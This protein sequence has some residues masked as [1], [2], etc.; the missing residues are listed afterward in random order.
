MVTSWKPRD[1][2]GL[3]IRLA[4]VWVFIWG[5][6]NLLAAVKQVFL[7]ALTQGNEGTN[8]SSF[9]SWTLFGL[10]APTFASL[11][12]FRADRITSLSYGNI[13]EPSNPSA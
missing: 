12:L 2:F 7:F 10:I 13:E 1:V 5:V 3:A 8:L 11:V 9:L 4:A 6:W